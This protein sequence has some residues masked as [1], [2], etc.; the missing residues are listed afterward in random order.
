[1]KPC[2]KWQNLERLLWCSANAACNTALLPGAPLCKVCRTPACG[3]TTVPWHLEKIR[4][5]IRSLIRQRQKWVP[6]VRWLH[7]ERKRERWGERWREVGSEG[8]WEGGANSESNMVNLESVTLSESSQ[9]RKK[10]WQSDVV[11]KDVIQPKTPRAGGPTGPRHTG[12]CMLMKIRRA[13]A[14]LTKGY[15]Y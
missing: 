15:K 13:S 6:P 14:Q 8:R 12:S 11:L 10:G 4:A 7:T 9:D 2:S 3:L 1:M 5:L